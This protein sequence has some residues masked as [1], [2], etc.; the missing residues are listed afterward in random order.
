MNG[1]RHEKFRSVTGSPDIGGLGAE[2]G[3]GLTTPDMLWLGGDGLD[4][5]APA[6]TWLHA[7]RKSRANTLVVNRIFL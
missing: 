7:V 2:V 1:R 3:V 4:R 5:P 6:E